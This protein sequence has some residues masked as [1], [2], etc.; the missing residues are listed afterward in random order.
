MSDNLNTSGVG[1]STIT[2]LIQLLAS[3]GI[4]ALVIIFMVYQQQ[5]ARLALKETK[6][7]DRPYYQRQ[8][9]IVLWTTIGLSLLS[10]A[11]WIYTAFVYQ[12]RLCIEGTIKDLTE[13]P[14]RPTKEGEP[15]LVKH[16]IA[17]FRGDANFYSSWKPTTSGDVDLGWAIV[18]SG[19]SQLLQLVSGRSTTCWVQ[20]VSTKP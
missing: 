17:A 19:G 2:Q 18:S 8:N 4:Y 16:T 13:Q 15:P 14:N 5:R 20:G 11:V 6:D 1:L 9:T 10:A 3:Y 12:P 7:E